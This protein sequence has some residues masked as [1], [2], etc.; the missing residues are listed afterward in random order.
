MTSK[1][2][3]AISSF[4]VGTANSGVPR[5]RILTLFVYAYLNYVVVVQALLIVKHY[6]HETRVVKDDIGQN[7]GILPF[8]AR[9]HSYLVP[10][11]LAKENQ[12]VFA[13]LRGGMR[14]VQAV[15]G[16]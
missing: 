11:P 3:S 5:N 1:R 16:S 10:H 4:S 6:V 12:L 2:S 13:L 8:L 15:L 7:S 9:Q 14:H